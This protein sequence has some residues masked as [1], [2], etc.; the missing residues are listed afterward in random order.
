METWLPAEVAADT[1]TQP[2]PPIPRTA[3]AD[4]RR[5]ELTGPVPGPR[6]VVTVASTGETCGEV[7]EVAEEEVWE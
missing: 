2:P 5:P 4:I 3:R 6:T 1:A 7:V